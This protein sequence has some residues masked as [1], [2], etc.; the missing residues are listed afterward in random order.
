MF[1]S[2]KYSGSECYVVNYETMQTTLS[3][4]RKLHIEVSGRYHDKLRGVLNEFKQDFQLLLP[5]VRSLLLVLWL[6][7]YVDLN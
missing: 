1:E 5:L 7:R 4:V 2:W 3:V 6:T